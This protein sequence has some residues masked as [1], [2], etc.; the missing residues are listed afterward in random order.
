MT[1]DT[2]STSTSLEKVANWDGN[3]QDISQVLTVAFDARDHLYCIRNL[4]AL[5]IDPLSYINNLDKIIEDLPTKSELRKR[6]IR[7][8]RKTCGL[9]GVLPTSYAVTCTL[10]KPGPLC[11]ASGAFS[12]VWRLT[13]EDHCDRVF[14]VKSLRVY[15]LDDTNEINKKYCKEVIVRKRAKHPNILS[16]EGVAPKLFE[17]CMVS[18]WMPNGN[19]LEYITKHPA[20][21]RLELVYLEHRRFDHTLT[22]LQLI[23]VTRGL[24]YLHN[25]EVIHGGLRSSNI[26]ID[27]KGSPRLSDFGLVSIKKD[28]N[29]VNAEE[30]NHEYMVRY[31]APELLDTEEAVWFKKKPTIKSDVYSLSMVIVELVTGNMPFPD[32]DD[33]D[34]ITTVCVG[35]R[36]SK[37]LRSGAP[38]ITPAV[39]KIAQKCWNQKANKRLEVNA[40]LQNLE[41]IANPGDKQ[42]PSP[43]KRAWRDIFD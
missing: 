32:L 31:C 35:G 19:I 14:A 5:G 33:P 42:T 30:P 29:S 25:N 15:E 24:D 12:D 16:I 41:R 22:K 9:Y 34:V 23:G 36:P 28:I 18:E 17:F 38:G 37:S 4:R 8:L 27:A 13:D 10:S 43:F 2:I 20:V 1:T 3:S 7:A 11:F 39:W 6:C 40:V 21:D 26:L